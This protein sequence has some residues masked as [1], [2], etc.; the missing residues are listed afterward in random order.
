MKR[1][2]FALLILLPREARA[3]SSC[4]EQS[5]VTGDRVC[6]RF[7]DGWSVERMPQLVL[8]AGFT[9]NH[10]VPSA[11][12]WTGTF[13]KDHPTKFRVAGDSLGMR[14]IDDVGFDFR[15]TGFITKTTYVGIDWGLG[16]G[17][18]QPRF[19]PRDGYEL[20]PKSG[21]NFVQAKIAT[22]VGAR[23]PL[24]PFSVRLEA[25]VGVQVASVSGELRPLNGQWVSGSFT[26]AALLLEPRVAV[27][28]WT[29]PW[30][31]ITL[32]GGGNALY[33]SDR[34]MGLSFSLHGRSF[35]GHY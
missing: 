20:R 27:D 31:T 34:S 13:G 5:D 10:L 28:V 32:W 2:L 30:S 9:T 23:L 25:L 29:T 11:R 35:D 26:N 15:L 33:A 21:I 3:H 1:L 22:V 7:G 18:V 16:F 14:A 8:A 24:G 19:A 12:N 6:S 4:V 17:S